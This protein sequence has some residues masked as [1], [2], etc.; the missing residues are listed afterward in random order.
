MTTSRE[1]VERILALNRE[2]WSTGKIAKE[3]GISKSTVADIIK[4]EKGRRKS[5]DSDDAPE[6]A[7]ARVIDGHPEPS[8]KPSEKSDATRPLTQDEAIANIRTYLNITKRGYLEARQDKSLA[9]DKRTWQEAQYLK[10]YRD[11]IRM[12]IEC[13][14]L[15]KLPPAEVPI[16]PLDDLARAIEDY[17]EDP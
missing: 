1:T 13:T 16:S 8:E 6:P 14:G 2:K 3:I 7:H 4:R 10:L 15:D 17:R 11:G 12:M 5:D 9:P